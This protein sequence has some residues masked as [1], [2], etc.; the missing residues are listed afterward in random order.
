MPLAPFD[1]A[2]T[3]SVAREILRRV[4]VEHASERTV[5]DATREVLRATAREDG[6]RERDV[7]ARVISSEIDAFLLRDDAMERDA[8]GKREREDEHGCS[9]GD[10]ERALWAHEGWRGPTSPTLA[11]KRA[12]NAEAEAED[13]SEERV[14]A[15]L[16]ALGE[17]GGDAKA[18]AAFLKR[19]KGAVNRAL[20]AAKARGAARFD[21]SQPGAPT[22][23]LAGDGDAETTKSARAVTSS[24]VTAQGSSLADVATS[25]GD[26]V[27]NEVVALA[28]TKRVTVRKWNNATLV[29][30][31]EYY[32]NGGEG[33]YLPGKKGISLSV[34]QWKALRAKIDEIKPAIEEC[35]RSNAETL[36]CEL[37]R[38][39]RCTVSKF[40]GRI[41]VNIREYYEKDGKMLPGQK[42]ASLSTDAALR[43]IAAAAKIDER[44][45]AL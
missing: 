27:D 35:E 42:G 40:K 41:L 24:M 16:R 20:Y 17:D 39:R 12:R 44:L 38:M 25:D 36:V 8:R 7:D 10:F 15:A 11:T 18:I 43:L 3:R 5:R 30:I 45:A 37:S 34:D 23:F 33:P 22:W 26:A 19:D 2:R 28:P 9:D 32:Q 31:R 1:E 13:V 4:D 14:L 6:D 21:E 29:D